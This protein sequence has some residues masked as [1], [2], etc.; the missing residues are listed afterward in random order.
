MHEAGSAGPDGPEQAGAAGRRRPRSTYVRVVR[1]G[2]GEVLLPRVHWRRSF[3]GRLR[4]LMFRRG[5]APG[6]AILL[7]ERADSRAATA[8]HMF[9]VSFP[10]AAVWIDSAG[11]VVDKALARPW[12]PYYAPRA[13]A[14][15]VLETAPEFLQLVNLDDAWVLEPI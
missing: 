11:R 12:R 8:I 6:E 10:I 9:F 13:P 2:T 1:Q 15:Y 5:L 14:R 4:G 3:L 7:D